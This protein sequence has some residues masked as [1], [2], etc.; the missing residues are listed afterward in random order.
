LLIKNEKEMNKKQF[1]GIKYPF[2]SSDIENYYIDLNSS[3]KDK[4]KSLLIHVI[5]TPKGQRLRDGEFGTNLIQF[6]YQPNDSQT[7][8][9]IKEEVSIAV[10]RY[11][12]GIQIKDIQVLQSDNVDEDVFVRID[13]TIM[14]G[15]TVE[16]DSLITKI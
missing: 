6:L 5:F 14:N 13:Y 11:I 7:W 1:Y 2:I 12:K 16:N 10:N 9:N 15:I 4:I 8:D 3:I